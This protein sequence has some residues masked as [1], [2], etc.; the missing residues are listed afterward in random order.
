MTDRPTTSPIRLVDARGEG[1]PADRAR[2]LEHRPHRAHRP[3][4][5]AD[6]PTAPPA[7]AASDGTSANR[8]STC[9]R[10]PPW[11]SSWSRD[12]AGRYG[13]TLAAEARRKGVDIVLG[14]T[15]NLHRSP[16]RR[17]PLRVHERGSAAR[18]ASSPPPMSAASSPAAWRRDAQ[19]LRRQRLRDRPL[20]R[21]RRRRRAPA[22]R[23]VPA[24][25]RAGGRRRRGVVD[26]ERVQRHQRRHRH[27]ERPA[28]DAAAH[29]VGIRR[30]RHQRLDRR[31]LAAQRDQGAGPRD[32]GAA[33]AVGP[34]RSST[35]C[36]P[37]RSTRR[38]IDRKVARLLLLAARV[39][40][41]TIDGR[42][43]R[44]VDRGHGVDDGF[45]RAAA[46]AGSVL[47]R[48]EG[49]LPLDPSDARH[50]RRSSATTPATPAR[51]AAAAPRCC[52]RRVSSPLDGAR[53]R[54][55]RQG[56]LRHRRRRPSGHRRAPAGVD[57]QPGDRRTRPAGHVPRRRRQRASSPRTVGPAPS[58]TSAGT[59]RSPPRARSRCTP[60]IGP[61]STAR[62]VLGFAGDQPGEH[63]RRRHRDPPRPPRPR[64]H[65]PR[66]RLPRPAVGRRLP[67]RCAPARC[68]TCSSR[69]DLSTSARPAGQRAVVHVRH[70]ARQLRPRRPDP[71][72]GRAGRRRATSPSS[73][74]GT[75]SRVESEGYDRT[76]LA[77]PGRQDDL[78]R[79]V[80][81]AN[82][83]TIVVVNAGSP[84]LMPWRD[85]VAAILLT[86]FPGQDF[87]D[88]LVDMLL[89]AARA[90]RPPADDVAGRR[91]PDPGHRRD[92]DRR[93]GRLRRGH[94]HRLPGVAA[95]RRDRGPTPS[96][97]VSA[98]PR[99]R[100]TRPPRPR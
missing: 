54:A 58:S 77:L 83:N 88:A 67:S 99:G 4:Q 38:T 46:V 95:Q 34:K 51:K 91:G 81:A 92:P 74:S 13:E 60:A 70:R 86:Y 17:A 61:R 44:R 47:L 22:A 82:P 12:I 100:S 45:A 63:R 37:A 24:P 18:A 96:A 3:A 35:P 85:D 14:P 84:V 23:A 49:A 50:D 27:R 20:Q 71:R 87:G 89:G 65:R 72:G 75:N 55:R 30:R 94:P 33:R 2:L 78:V 10:G 48:N 64:R 57:D 43:R 19:A 28:R 52:R 93:Q 36:G 66:R 15:I 80:A 90:R 21:R 32:A 53:R 8:R 6:A 59:P 42:S 79:A 26:H 31:A 7:S 68:S 62:S 97:S 9:R 56:A 29:R 69:V 41:I 40:A 1:R 39:G 16:L 76:S 5:H 98:T 73:S 11:P 25:V